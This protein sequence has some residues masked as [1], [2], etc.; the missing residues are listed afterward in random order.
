MDIDILTETD[1]PL[2]ER[3]ELKFRIVH[4]QSA[5]PSRE[6]VA[7]KLAAVMNAE[8]SRTIIRKINSEFGLNSSI[9]YANIYETDES[10]STEPKYI[11]ARNGIGGDDQ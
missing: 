3:K 11:L 5:T 7:S 10:V 4:E 9:G 6:T 2:L 8:R 1:N